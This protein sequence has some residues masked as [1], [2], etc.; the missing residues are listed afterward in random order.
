MTHI[1][2]KSALNEGIISEEFENKQ[3]VINYFVSKGKTA[4]QGAAAWERG[5]RGPTKKRLSPFDQNYIPKP[6]DNSRYGEN[7]S[8]KDV[9]ESKFLDKPTLSVNEL[10][11]KHK[12]SVDSILAQLKIGIKSELEHTSDHKIAREIALD[13]LKE[14]PNYY[15]LLNKFDLEE[16]KITKNT[17]VPIGEAWEAEMIKYIKILESK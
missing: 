9:A 15:T 6:V 7:E 17:C 1:K 5:W 16:Q 13:H 14:K 11:K 2:R 12:V 10:S 3:Q 8:Q 4:A